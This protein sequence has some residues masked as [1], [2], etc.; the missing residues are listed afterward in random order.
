MIPK[1]LASLV[2]RWGIIC[3]WLNIVYMQLAFH[4]KIGLLY[5]ILTCPLQNMVTVEYYR[6]L[7]FTG[8]RQSS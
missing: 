1:F 4:N 7:H 6:I 8:V 3:Q 2:V 5:K